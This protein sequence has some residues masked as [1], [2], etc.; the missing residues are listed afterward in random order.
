MIQKRR[1]DRPSR[2]SSGGVI[3]AVQKPELAFRDAFTEQNVQPTSSIHSWRVRS[4][5]ATQSVL[6]ET[7]V[8]NI[9]LPPLSPEVFL[10]RD[11][12]PE[13]STRDSHRAQTRTTD[14]S[15]IV[16]D[17]E[18]PSISS[19]SFSRAARPEV[20]WL[21]LSLS[22]MSVRMHRATTRVPS[23]TACSPSSGDTV[24]AVV[25]TVPSPRQTREG[26]CDCAR[27][28]TAATAA[29]TAA[30]AAVVVPTALTTAR[31]G[32]QGPVLEIVALMDR[33]ETHHTPETAERDIRDQLV[34]LLLTQFA[35]LV[36]RLSPLIQFQDV[37]E[38]RHGIEPRL[39]QESLFFS[40]IQ[41]LQQDGTIPEII[42]DVMEEA[43]ISIDEVFLLWFLP[44]RMV[45]LALL[46]PGA[47]GGLLIRPE[48]RQQ[49]L[50]HGLSHEE[51]GLRRLEALPTHIQLNEV[52][53]MQVDVFRALLLDLLLEELLLLAPPPTDAPGTESSLDLREFLAPGAALIT[54]ATA[55]AGAAAAALVG[56]IVLVRA[57][58]GTDPDLLRGLHSGVCQT[59]H[60]LR[61]HID[62]VHL[63]LSC[64]DPRC[65]LPTP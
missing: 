64:R 14:R 34:L 23:T 28:T 48:P 53:C 40:P 2:G 3:E 20:S 36:A 52:P 65:T 45:L 30:A 15:G 38:I 47:G 54:T 21:Q 7:D 43:R 12:V 60:F 44:L 35:T 27:D 61:R 8:Q 37:H 42:Q 46:T 17:E 56:I 1:E 32:C 63:Q 51:C 29:A 33:E 24:V 18:I 22:R 31:H 41:F 39:P 19:S 11:C 5:Q 49:P 58:Q 62:P 4:C 16:G 10:E 55:A 13:T 25:V 26:S 6:S 50:E 9:T 57:L 59:V